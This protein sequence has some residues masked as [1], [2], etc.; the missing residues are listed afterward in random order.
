MAPTPSESR[1]LICRALEAVADVRRAG[2][3]LRRTIA[4]ARLTQAAFA[5]T[6]DDYREADRL[7]EE[8]IAASAREREKS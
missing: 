6:V 1:E 2:D 5:R 3:T 4:R 7:L 8:T